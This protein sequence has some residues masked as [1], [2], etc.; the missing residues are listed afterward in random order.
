ML[1][2]EYNETGYKKY[3]FKNDKFQNTTEEEKAKANKNFED[4]VAKVRNE[5][6]KHPEISSFCKFTRMC[7]FKYI[8][9]NLFKFI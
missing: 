6:L 9:V 8:I 2:K 5:L 7:V 4:D 1:K 3:A